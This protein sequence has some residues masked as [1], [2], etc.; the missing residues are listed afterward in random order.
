MWKGEY[1]M[2]KLKIEFITKIYVQ[3]KRVTIKNPVD[4]VENGIYLIPESRRFQGLSVEHSIKFN[5]EIP[6][7]KK[8]AKKVHANY[9]DYTDFLKDSGGYLKARYAA[10]DGYH[11]KNP[12]YTQ[13]GKVVGKYD[14]ALDH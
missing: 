2:E 7:L 8:L 6:I 13:F 1:F 3:G 9:L 12:A 4:A 14:K 10:G 5:I 11:W